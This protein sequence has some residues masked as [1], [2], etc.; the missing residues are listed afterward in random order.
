MRVAIIGG[1]AAGFFSALS[2]KE[3]HPNSKV[4]I[5]ASR[6]DHEKVRESPGAPDPWVAGLANP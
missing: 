5:F 2:V 6:L 1:G 3:H 4:T